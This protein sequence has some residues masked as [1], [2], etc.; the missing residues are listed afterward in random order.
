ML[1]WLCCSRKARQSASSQSSKTTC[2][3]RRTIRRD[4]SSSCSSSAHLRFPKSSALPSCTPPLQPTLTLSTQAWPTGLKP[5]LFRLD[6]KTLLH[7]LNSRHAHPRRVDSLDS[8]TS[9]VLTPTLMIMVVLVGVSD[10]CRFVVN[11]LFKSFKS[12][13]LL[14]VQ[15]HLVVLRL[16]RD[17]E[18]QVRRF[19]EL[20]RH[21][22]DLLPNVFRL[23]ST[24]SL[25]LTYPL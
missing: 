13:D 22:R 20:A 24:T 23:K 15:L 16:L 11:L 1:C 10:V 18:I 7:R 12:F 6:R 8:V 14:L 19:R 5:T 21:S 3:L 9:C 2:L 17:V 4:A 25:F